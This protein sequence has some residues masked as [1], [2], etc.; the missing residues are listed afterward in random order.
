MAARYR[1]WSYI[2]WV[3]RDWPQKEKSLPGLTGAAL[4]EYEAVQAA[5]QETRALSGGADCL[6]LI[7]L[8]YWK[9]SHTMQ[10]A[11]EVLHVSYDTAVNWNRGFIKKVAEKM[12]LLDKESP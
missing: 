10:G 1:W 2:K 6:R 12:G 8:V 9:N 3:V 11:A 7:E 4:R 5:V